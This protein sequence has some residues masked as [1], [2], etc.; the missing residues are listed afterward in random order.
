MT[1]SLSIRGTVL[2]IGGVTAKVE[3]AAKAGIKRVIIPKANL[4]DVL[5][6]DKF[7]DKIKIIPVEII[8]EVIDN[9]LIGTGKEKLL[10]KLK[11]MKPLKITGKVEL[12][13]EKKITTKQHLKSKN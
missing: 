1:G 9:A 4:N 2:P 13:S 6:E 10:K 8:T 11:A 12:E 7:K 5:I 3:A